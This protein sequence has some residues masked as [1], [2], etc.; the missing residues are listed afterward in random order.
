MFR[1]HLS[2]AVRETPGRIGK[3]GGEL[4]ARRESS[5][6]G[7]RIGAYDRHAAS[8]TVAKMDGMAADRVHA[9][10]EENGRERAARNF[11]RDVAL[12]VFDPDDAEAIC[13]IAVTEITPFE[14]GFEQA[15]D[16]CLP[17]FRP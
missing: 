15:F 13:Q 8:L 3:D 7:S 6:I 14:F 9:L 10:H 12:V 5:Q 2:S 1:G 11:V 4:P 17:I 16:M